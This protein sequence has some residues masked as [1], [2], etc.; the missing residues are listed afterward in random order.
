M[1]IS[2]TAVGI[3]RAPEAQ[4]D[5]RGIGKFE[6]CHI[7]DGEISGTHGMLD[8]NQGLR[9]ADGQNPPSHIPPLYVTGDLG[10]NDNGVE[11]RHSNQSQGIGFGYNTIYATGYGSGIG[12]DLSLKAFGTGTVRLNGG[13]AITS[14]D[15]LKINE[16]YLT[17]ATETLL[18]LKPQVYDKHQKIN[19]ICE[20]PVREAGLITQDVYYDAP[21]LRFL[22]QARNE[23]LDAIIPV[24]IPEE[25]PFIDDDPTKDPDY[26][27]WGT[28][29]ASLN[30]EG[31]IPYLIKSNQELH[32]EIQTL[33][34]KDYT[35]ELRIENNRLKSKVTILENRQTH[36]NT[37]LVNLIGRVETLERPA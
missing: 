25:K 14:D 30:Y 12:Q 23:G 7:R 32:A 37:L 36:F 18:K 2:D 20:N 10:S 8:I 15:R 16:Q 13:T 6:T 17:N 3:G 5:V 1:V 28:D 22:V 34:H 11:F 33:E 19:E 9:T 29:A 24:N 27:G 26:S 31:F 4:L 21:E 35:R